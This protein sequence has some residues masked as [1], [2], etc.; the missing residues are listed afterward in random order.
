MR[1]RNK[2]M[3]LRLNEKEYQDLLE[4]AE[5]SGLPRST[6]CREKFLAAEVIPAPTVDY[7]TLIIEVKRVGR[8]IELVLQ[9][10]NI[11]GIL[12]VPLLRNALEEAHGLNQKLWEVFQGNTA[13]QNYSR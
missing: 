3:I 10:S 12:D 7:G 11:T 9:K 8:L 2:K 4:Q 6:Y 1:K 13:N 5:Q